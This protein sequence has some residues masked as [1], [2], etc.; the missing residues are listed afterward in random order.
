M[1][2]KI[3]KK[4]KTVSSYDE[5][6]QQE[7]LSYILKIEKEHDDKMYSQG[8]AYYFSEEAKINGKK[9]SGLKKDYVKSFPED[10]LT[11][12]A[13]LFQILWYYVPEYP[14][15]EKKIFTLTGKG[16][17]YEDLGEYEKA[18]EYYQEADDLTM[19]VCRKDIQEL[20]RDHGPGD[21]LYCATIRRRIRVC[22]KPLI[23][24]LELEAKS[25][26]KSNPRE[27]IKIYKE[28]NRLKPGLKKYNKRIEICKKKL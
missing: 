19:E 21:Y 9:V 16:K 20:V 2:N 8:K 23:K 11:T 3:L 6:S 24:E 25:L 12:G 13:D 26:E 7:K 14:D 5:M 10:F 1:F 17:Y 28:L 22:S 15:S 4:E 27:A 18:I